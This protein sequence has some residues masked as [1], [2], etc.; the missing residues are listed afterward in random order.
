MASPSERN[1]VLPTQQQQQQQHQDIIKTEDQVQ[2]S[3][4]ETTVISA[5]GEVGN[6]SN[7][8]ILTNLTNKTSSKPPQQIHHVITVPGASKV[9]TPP[10]KTIP[11]ARSISSSGVM[12]GVQFYL[13]FNIR[14]SF[15]LSFHFLICILC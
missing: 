4:L 8:I 9:K 12:T 7:E 14:F 6:N 5:V 3:V 10:V 11:Q 1:L 15:L 13:C 2:R